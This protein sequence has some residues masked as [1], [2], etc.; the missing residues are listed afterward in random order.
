MDHSKIDVMYPLADG[1]LND[2]LELRYSL[3]ALEKHVSNIDTVF[4]IGDQL[5]SWVNNAI[6]IPKS[7][8]AREKQVNILEQIMVM[9]NYKAATDNF[10]FMNDDHFFSKDVI[11]SQLPYFNKG[12]LER[13]IRNHHN[14]G[15]HRGY[16][17]T[18]ENTQRE[19]ERRGLST[20]NY[21]IHL[22][23]VYNKE[24]FLEIASQ[25]DWNQQQ[26]L[27]IKS[28]YCNTLGVKGLRVPDMRFWRPFPKETVLKKVQGAIGFSVS[29]SGLLGGFIE[30]L[31]KL[32]PNK[33]K[34]E[35]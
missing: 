18:L 27:A 14:S 7:D 6:W 15:V 21:D 35:I 20:L 22:P 3:R 11:A 10:L 2:N 9:C 12:E 34:Y 5:P 8:T 16:V 17:N 19:L 25:Y 33:S 30:A 1:S 29:D 23:I 32:Y 4:I 13:G 26:S 28:I 24:K 31:E